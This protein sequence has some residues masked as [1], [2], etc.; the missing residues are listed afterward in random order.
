[1]QRVE[2]DGGDVGAHA[3][4]VGGSEDDGLDLDRAAAADRGRRV[5]AAAL[6]RQAGVDDPAGGAGHVV[7]ADADRLVAR[8]RLG[9]HELHVGGER[10][11]GGVEA[12]AVDERD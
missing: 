9:A 8:D 7:E 6:R 4:P 5:A 12:A 10:G 3:D 11:G 1:M 2:G